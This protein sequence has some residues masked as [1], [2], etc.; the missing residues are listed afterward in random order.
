WN[1]TETAR[2]MLLRQAVVASF[3]W[4]DLETDVAE[5]IRRFK[6]VK[7]IVSY[8]NLHEVPSDLEQIYERMCQ[9]DADVVKVSVTAQQP[10][11]N[12]RVL[13]LLKNAKKPTVALCMGDIGGASR[14]LCAKYGAAFTYAVFNKDYRVAPGILSF[15]DLKHV[16][17]YDGINPQTHVFGVIGDP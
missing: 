8:H 5:E 13:A 16:Y 9:Q 11:D 7:R 15:D 4:V 6:D 2:R 3:D 1:G 17:Q 12:L 10:A 14:I